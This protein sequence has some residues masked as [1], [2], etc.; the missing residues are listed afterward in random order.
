MKR[1]D[2]IKELVEQ[3][4]VLL[5][6]VIDMFANTSYME[7]YWHQ[8]TNYPMLVDIRSHSLEWHTWVRKLDMIV[9]PLPEI[10]VH[11]QTFSD[12]PLSPPA[13]R[14]GFFPG[15]IRV[16]CGFASRATRSTLRVR[17]GQCG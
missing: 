9:T 4:D 10:I 16:A 6:P 8:Y 5:I 12:K 2:E 11:C 1:D 3:G 13:L 17:T 7:N 14:G 15:A